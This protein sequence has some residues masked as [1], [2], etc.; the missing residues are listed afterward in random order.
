MD[1]DSWNAYEVVACD[2]SRNQVFKESHDFNSEGG[3]HGIVLN[4][5]K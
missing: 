5:K 4:L 1:I 2:G 3:Q